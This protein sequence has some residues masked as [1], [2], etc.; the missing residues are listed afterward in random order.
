MR[1]LLAFLARLLFPPTHEPRALLLKDPN[2]KPDAVRGFCEQC[3]TAE[4]V[5]VDRRRRDLTRCC[6]GC[7]HP[8]ASA[9]PAICR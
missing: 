7:F 8:V 5:C 6:A 1:R 2:A 3:S 4:F 9:R